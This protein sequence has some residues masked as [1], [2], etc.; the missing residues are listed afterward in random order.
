VLFDVLSFIDENLTSDLSVP[1][2]AARAQISTRQLARAFLIETKLAPRAYV[3]QRRVNAA[4]RM[5][6]REPIALNQIALRC[7]FAAARTLARAFKRSFG[8]SPGRY[9]AGAR[10]PR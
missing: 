7:G 1:A 3:E 6:E 9:R 5:L 10:L 2:L 4:A 8:I